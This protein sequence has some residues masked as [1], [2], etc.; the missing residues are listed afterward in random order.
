MNPRDIPFVGSEVEYGLAG[1]EKSVKTT[2]KF[3][4]STI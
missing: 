3:R 2:V 4:E 1:L